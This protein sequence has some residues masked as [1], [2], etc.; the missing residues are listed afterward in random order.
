MSRKSRNV[1]APEELYAL[2]D[3]VM[4]I[5][6]MGTFSEYVRDL[7]RRDIEEKVRLGMLKLDQ[8]VA[9]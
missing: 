7:M 1:S 2:V 3:Q 4:E 5:R 6:H 9:A 8:E